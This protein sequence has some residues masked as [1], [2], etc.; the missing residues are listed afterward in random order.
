MKINLKDVPQLK[1][2]DGK[3]VIEKAELEKEKE[4]EKKDVRSFSFS[5]SSKYLYI[6]LI[7][8]IAVILYAILQNPRDFLAIMQDKIFLFFSLSQIFLWI[9]LMIARL[10]ATESKFTIILTWIMLAL[11]MIPTWLIPTLE[12]L[13]ISEYF[14]TI[15]GAGYGILHYFILFE[16]LII[17]ETFIM[18][19]I[20]MIIPP[21]V[22]EPYI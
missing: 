9:S 5:F 1:E 11:W 22:K 21:P 16:E 18:G 14:T 10:R 19:S 15:Y 13:Y 17:G 12:P 7:I 3:S 20:Y 6:P 4:I 2:K 8:G